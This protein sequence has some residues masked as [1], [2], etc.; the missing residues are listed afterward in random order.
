MSQVIDYWASAYKPAVAE[1]RGWGP[2]AYGDRMDQRLRLAALC[3]RPGACS[4]GPEGNPHQVDLKHKPSGYFR[5]G[6]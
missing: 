2:E 5:P 4:T 6:D 1:R 3:W